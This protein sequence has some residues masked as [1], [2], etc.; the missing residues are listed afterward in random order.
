MC[1]P[2][3][4]D[5]AFFVF[6]VVVVTMCGVERVARKDHSI[7]SEMEQR[8]MGNVVEE[9]T[10]ERRMVSQLSIKGSS[11]IFGS[12]KKNTGIST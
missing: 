9:V 7:R 1:K 4:T 5:R 6:L 11:S 8:N 3:K 2:T 10:N 12:T